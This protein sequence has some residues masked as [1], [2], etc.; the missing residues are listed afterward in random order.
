M[1]GVNSGLKFDQCY[2]NNDIN[3]SIKPGNYKLFEDSTINRNE[4]NSLFGTRSNYV[5]K[6]PEIKKAGA[7]NERADIENLL[8]GLDRQSTKCNDTLEVLREK[9]KKKSD[10]LD[11][12]KMCNK[13]LDPMHSRLEILDQKEMTTIHLQNE[14]PITNPQNEIHYG[15]NNTNLLNPSNSRFGKN[16]RLEEK[17][18]YSQKFISSN[19]VKTHKYDKDIF[20]DEC[21]LNKKSWNCK[22][23]KRKPVDINNETNDLKGY[24][25]NLVK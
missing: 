10:K 4:C 6:N 20:C 17:D 15:H 22:T 7:F 11:D 23:C 19:K 8:I 2:I 12:F 18:N 3:Q 13:Y 16:T 1:V 24:P 21:L 14:F 9:L 5:G 25:I